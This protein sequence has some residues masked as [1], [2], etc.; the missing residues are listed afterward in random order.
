ME[1]SK[2]APPHVDHDS[3]EDSSQFINMKIHTP[4][5]KIE[6]E[7]TDASDIE[8]VKASSAKCVRLAE[9]PPKCEDHREH[10]SY[11]YHSK[12]ENPFHE[13]GKVGF[14]VFIWF[15]MIAFLTS[16][17]EKKIEKRQLVIPVD[18]PKVFT[19]PKLPTG[20]LVNV[21]IQAPFLPEP[22]E[23]NRKFSSLN[24]DNRNK[25]NSL[26]I[27]LKTQDGKILTTNKTFYISKP[28]E[29]DIVNATKLD[30]LFDIGEENLDDLHEA[31]VIQAV[32]VS[33]FS[34][35]NYRDKQEM[36]IIFSYDFEPLNKNIGVLFA[37]FVL[38]L[39]YA[40][41]IWEVSG[42]L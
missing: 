3:D 21:T 20:T 9:S 12:A 41:I 17:P 4:S 29:I 18:E 39:L 42:C 2:I 15:L 6:D 34:K 8:N 37:A 25:D 40:L 36:P 26:I 28:E 13:F 16:S 22:K 38:M 27:F 24:Q 1:D 33:N 14:L 11:G 30:F 32:M 31:D 10:F 5:T 7:K 23:Y 35:S 19:F